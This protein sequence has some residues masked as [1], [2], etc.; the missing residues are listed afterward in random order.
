[1]DAGAGLDAVAKRK[2]P[3]S[4]RKLSLKLNPNIYYRVQN[5][6]LLSPVLIQ[7]NPVH[8]L[9]TLLPENIF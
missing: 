6:R 4:A 2:V 5:S 8:T 9:H 3:W 7:N 1:M